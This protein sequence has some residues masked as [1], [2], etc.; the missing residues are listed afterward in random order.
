MEIPFEGHSSEK[1]K[2][3]VTHNIYSYAA[4]NDNLSNMFDVNNGTLSGDSMT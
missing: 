3:C 4:K 2:K 1:K